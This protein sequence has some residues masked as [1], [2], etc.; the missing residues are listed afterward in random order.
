[1]KRRGHALHRRYGRASKR[2][3]L[4]GATR[5]RDLAIGDTFEDPEKF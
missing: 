1:M 2:A 5:F 3:L 4:A